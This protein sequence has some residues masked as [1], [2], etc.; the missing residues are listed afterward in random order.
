MA[1]VQHNVLTDPYIHEPKGITT[2][3]ANRV[4]LADGT[5][6]GSWGQVP[7]AGLTGINGLN[8]LTLT[9]M[10]RNTYRNVSDQI[11]ET[12][13]ADHLFILPYDGEV[14]TLRYGLVG[15][16]T[17]NSFDG[18]TATNVG[19]KAWIYNG[20]TGTQFVNVSESTQGGLDSSY[21]KTQNP[22][23]NN[24]FVSG[25]LLH[26]RFTGLNS[27]STNEIDTIVTAVLDIT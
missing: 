6:S 2:A 7:E 25:D 23:T 16:N 27:A 11:V 1:D 10:Q 12:S 4:Y 22:T 13:Q 21:F 15:I 14:K 3:S 24:T 9:S 5:G 26:V 8:E 17:S 18:V 20:S 19:F